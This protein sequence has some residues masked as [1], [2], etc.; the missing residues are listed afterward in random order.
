MVQTIEPD[1]DMSVA[2]LGFP[3]GPVAAPDGTIYVCDVHGGFIR[4][5]RDGR[6]SVFADVG[7]GPNGLAFG[8]DGWLYV[9][10][11]GGAMRWERRDGLLLSHGF[12]S[13][14]FDARIERIHPKTGVVERVLDEIDGRPLQ[15]IDDLVFDQDGSFWFTDLGRDGERSRSYGGL[16]WASS[17]GRRR[18]EAAYPLVDGANGIGLSPDGK[19]LYATEYGAGRLWAW[20]VKAPGIL[21]KEPGH[22]H[23]GRLLWQAPDAQLL[24]SLAVAASGNIVIATQPGGVFS[25]V[26]PSGTL[27]ARVRMP[28]AFP[29]NLCFNVQDPGIAYATLSSSGQLARIR[30]PE[31]GPRASFT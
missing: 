31:P 23:G 26:S 17:D 13:D 2:G 8:S 4:Q 30:W 15:A 11:N 22:P 14:G 25:V 28:E 3:E 16:Y 21:E 5:V 27:L 9:A 19:T 10:N 12:K 6:H 7:G 18:R 1:I 20:T 29:T 24:D